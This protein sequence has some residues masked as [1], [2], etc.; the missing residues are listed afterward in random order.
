[1]WPGFRWS[2]TWSLTTLFSDACLATRWPAFATRHLARLA[3][4][5]IFRREGLFKYILELDSGEFPRGPVVLEKWLVDSWRNAARTLS[6]GTGLRTLSSAAQSSKHLL[7]K[8]PI[9]WT[10][11]KTL[12]LFRRGLACCGT[13]SPSTGSCKKTSITSTRQAS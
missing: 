10:N 5:H 3:K 9:R 7:L 2:P 11:A 12:V 6:A 1:M 8:G 4:N 13:L